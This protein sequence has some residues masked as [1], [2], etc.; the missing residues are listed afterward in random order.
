MAKDFDSQLIYKGGGYLDG[1]MQPVATLTDLLQMPLNYRFVGLTVTVLDDGSGEP[2]DYWLKNDR[3][4][5]VLKVEGA[6]YY[7]DEDELNKKNKN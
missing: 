6:T 3:F 2:H 1:K 4:T 7:E 5:W